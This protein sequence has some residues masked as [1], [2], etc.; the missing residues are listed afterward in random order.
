MKEARGKWIAMRDLIEAKVETEH[1]NRTSEFKR[2]KISEECSSY[3][4][5]LRAQNPVEYNDIMSILGFFET[6]GYVITR[7]FI[8]P[9]EMIDLY[10]ELI[11]GV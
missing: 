7:G 1:Q 11:L 2:T 8:P 4:F 10:G 5:S 9:D 6:V 3:L